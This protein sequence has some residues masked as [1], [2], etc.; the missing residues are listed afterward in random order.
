MGS[1]LGADALVLE[2]AHVPLRTAEGAGVGEF[3]KHD[4]IAL[5]RNDQ[6]VAFADVE[7]T[8]GFSRDDYATEI[9]D[10]PGDAG[11]HD[12]VGA[13]RLQL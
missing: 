2:P 8:A 1:A 6:V 13:Y 10:L 12:G 9:V 7:Q 3:A 11:V 5:H 4:V